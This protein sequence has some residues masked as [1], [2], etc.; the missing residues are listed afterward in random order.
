MEKKLSEISRE[1][2]ISYQWAD[3][4]QM[5][6][7]ERVFLRGYQRTPDEMYNAMMEWEETEEFRNRPIIN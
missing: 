2:W 5:G 6:D 3:V 1:E 7:S 4:T